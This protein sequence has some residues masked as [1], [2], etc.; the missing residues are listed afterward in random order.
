M[1]VGENGAVWK[2]IIEG[3]GRERIERE[4]LPEFLRRQRWFAG[5]AREVEAVRLADAVRPK[6]FPASS[7]LAL[8]EAEFDE[9]GPE[10]YFLPLAIASGRDAKRVGREVPERIIATW[11]TPDGPAAL[12]DGLVDPGTCWA[13]LTAIESN[14]SAP[15]GRGEIRALRTTAFDRARG[16]VGTPLEVIPKT[17]EQSNSVVLFDQRLLIK[18]FRRIEPGINPDFEIGKFLSEETRFDRIPQTAG[19]IEY[20]RSGSEPATLAVLQTLVLNQ[21]TGWDHALG[22]LRAFY[23]RVDRPDTP[24]DPAAAEALVGSYP[25]AAA[26]LGRRTAELH[27][28]LASDTSD[29]DFAPEPLTAAD[30]SFLRES[31]RDQFARPS[32]SW[33]TA[34][35]RGGSLPRCKPRPGRCWTRRQGLMAELDALPAARPGSTRIRCHGDYHLGQVLRVD[36]DFVIL[37]FEGEPARPLDARRR[38]ETPMK[39]VVGMLRSFNYAA[40]A[41][42]FQRTRDKPAD[43]DRLAPW[44]RLWA[45]RAS[46]AFLDAYRAAVGEADFVP[47]DPDAL[48]LLLRLFTLDKALYELWY[49]LNNRPDWVR[50]PIQG[51]L[52]LARPTGLAPGEARRGHP[53]MGRMA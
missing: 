32:S 38:K 48:G 7:F 41:A 25:A 5:K 53:L 3:P 12:Y 51:I 49:E 46:T 29:P 20:H 24:D 31:M 43:S 30:L 40:Y 27:R 35:A 16:P 26:L 1:V 18:V 11:E 34:S 14:R 44:A 42:L 10:T 2:A 47:A 22:E 33:K 17:T 37:D 39:D 50:I 8:T 45:A 19:T 6:G 28:A 9:G 21:G 36:D 52:A 13:L 15:T 23:E 4:A